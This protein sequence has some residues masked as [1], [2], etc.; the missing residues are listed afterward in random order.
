MPPR[1]EILLINL[2]GLHKQS[3]NR[4]KQSFALIFS[5]KMCCNYI[6]LYLTSGSYA[7]KTIDVP[8]DLNEPPS[9]EDS[10]AY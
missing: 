9:Y 10:F 3:Y 4:P 1:V 8:S 6:N 7:K 2:E 5:L